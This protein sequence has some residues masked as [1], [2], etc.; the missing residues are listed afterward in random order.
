[1]T[2]EEVF[3]YSRLSTL[4][5]CAQKY[6]LR[7]VEQ[8]E[9]LETSKSITRGREVE[10]AVYALMDYAVEK[11]T[12]GKLW[13]EEPTLAD[14]ITAFSLPEI[15]P[16]HVEIAKSITKGM[17]GGGLTPVTGPNGKPLIQGGLTGMIGG[18]PFQGFYD[19]ILR[20]REGKVSLVDLK[21]V[22]RSP[23][24]PFAPHSLQLR[25]YDALLASEDTELNRLVTETGLLFAVVSTKQTTLL[26]DAVPRTRL[27]SS[28]EELNTEVKMV[29]AQLS[30][31]KKMNFFPRKI[32][33]HYDSPCQMCSFE[34]L[35]LKG[36]QSQ[37][38]KSAA[39]MAAALRHAVIEDARS[40]W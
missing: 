1:M 5:S 10:K 40:F 11:T 35:C 31:Y 18:T 36:D 24:L 39:R 4:L 3:S 15:D 37:V 12:P 28:R 26:Y 17:I 14:E 8:W 7:Y 25:V 32:L 27:S 30:L 19:L 20:T 29:M 9:E 23:H 38:R 2:S 33:G 21:V 22:G 34:A 13:G 16:G 6:R